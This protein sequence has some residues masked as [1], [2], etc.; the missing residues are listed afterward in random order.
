MK[1]SI[2]S[3]LST[4]LITLATTG[5]C[6][7]GGVDEKVQLPEDVLPQLKPLLERAMQ[8][9]P[10]VLERNLD[11]VLAEADGYVARSS[12]LPSVGGYAQYQL[13][14][15]KLIDG[16]GWNNKDKLGYNFS[17]N[18]SVWQWGALEATRKISRIDRD[19]AKK[20]YSEAF[21]VLAGEVRS[22]YLGLVLNKMVVRNAELTFRLAQ[23]NLARQQARYSANQVTYGEIMT[24]QLRVDE[25]SLAMRRA[26]ADLVFLLDSFR[27]MCG[28]VALTEA[29]IPEAIGDITEAPAV[30]PVV[31][32]SAID[33]SAEVKIVE[34]EVE[35]AKLARVGPRYALYPKLGLTAGISRDQYTQP[36]DKGTYRYQADTAFIGTVVNWNLFDGLSSK[37]QRLAALTRLRRAEQKLVSSR[38]VVA[39]K[40]ARAS[41]NVGFTWDSYQVAKMHLRMASEGL[42]HQ[43]EEAGRGLVSQEQIDAAQGNVFSHQYYAQAALAAHLSAVVEYLSSKGADP[44]A[45]V[46]VQQH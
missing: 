26:K 10:K 8:Q 40:L 37:G 41:D 46:G 20:N 12:S 45:R 38:L 22:A 2:A 14:K 36:Q 21:R 23:G 44:V 18:Q 9:S 31:A 34:M 3:L 4:V 39:R 1:Q 11:L 13:Q 27:S 33:D 5:A 15:E 19:L 42:T 35:K 29:E 17:I 30:A 28:D 32:S 25:A 16:T 7:A 43:R 24:H 6:A